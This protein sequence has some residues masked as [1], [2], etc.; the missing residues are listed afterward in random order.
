M[1]GTS[2]DGIDVVLV[3]FQN[4][5]APKLLHTLAYPIPEALK[6]NLK[7]LIQSGPDEIDKMGE[8]DTELGKLLAEAVNKL[9]KQTKVPSHA[10]AA[11]GSH[12]QNIRHRPNAA[13]PFTLQIGD[14]N[15]LVAKTG[16][17]TVADFRRRD[18]ALGGRGAPLAPAF[19]D[20]LFRTP[21]ENRCIVNIGGIANL[22]LLNADPKLPVLGYDT[23]PGNTLMDNWCFEH[24]QQHYDKAGQWAASGQVHSELLNALLQDPYFSQPSPKSTGREYFNLSWLENYLKKFTIAP[25]DIQA[26]LS[27]L[28]ARSIS[29]NIQTHLKNSGSVWICGGGAHNTHLMNRIADL[30]K[31]YSVQTTAK[32]G[33][34]PDWI[35]AMAFAWF[36]LRTL[37]GKP[38]NIPSVTGASEASILG[39]IFP[40]STFREFIRD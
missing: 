18:M 1:A 2:L 30:C 3:D 34:D 8:V 36:A 25:E 6:H 26:T 4:E 33:I 39:A 7:M 24:L 23:G 27:E 11:I 28:T 13:S 14:P 15:I 35:E 32:M 5:H 20:L 12:G 9:L 17:T 38:S 40:S 29:E 21:T 16:I 37:N 19:H 10:I 22:S 31:D